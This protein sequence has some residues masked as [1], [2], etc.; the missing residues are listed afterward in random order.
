MKYN[1]PLMAQR[2]PETRDIKQETNT[3]VNNTF[4]AANGQFDKTFLRIVQ[5]H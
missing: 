3:T 5:K 4:T 1:V 2:S